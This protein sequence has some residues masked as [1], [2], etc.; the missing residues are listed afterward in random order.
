MADHAYDLVIR[1]AS[2]ADGTGAPAREG[3]IAIKGDTIVAVGKVAG[4]GRE[5]FDARGKLVTPG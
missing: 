1:G 4:R 3:D 5:V 2:I